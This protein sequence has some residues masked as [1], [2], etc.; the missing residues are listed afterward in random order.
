MSHITTKQL[1]QLRAGKHAYA[2]EGDLVKDCLRWLKSVECYVYRQNQGGM[3]T[4]TRF[5]RFAHVDGISDII[6]MTSTGRYIAV[7]CK[8]PGKRPTEKQRAFLD[9]VKAHGGIAIVAHDVDEL[10]AE[11]FA[12][13]IITHIEATQ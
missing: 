11:F 1:R 13:E 7:E 9:E 4:D 10:A 6:G 2:K 3:K 12:A 8:Q 5:I